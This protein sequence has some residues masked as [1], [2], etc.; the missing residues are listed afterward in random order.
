LSGSV[1]GP[2]FN[3]IGIDGGFVKVCLNVVEENKSV[4]D[5]CSS[6]AANAKDTGVKRLFFIYYSWYAGKLRKYVTLVIK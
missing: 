3:Q 5:K 1:I 2:T 4:L 6:L